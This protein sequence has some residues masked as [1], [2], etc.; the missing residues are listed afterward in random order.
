[1]TDMNLSAIDLNLLVVVDAVL[2][3]G[4]ATKAAELRVGMPRREADELLKGEMCDEVD[5]VARDEPYRFYPGIGLALRYRD[6]RVEEM[7]L[8]QAPRLRMPPKK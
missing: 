8:A 1:M 6:S 7:V 2:E 5:L 3:T 4:S